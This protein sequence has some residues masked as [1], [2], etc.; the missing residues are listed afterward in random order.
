MAH[1]LVLP[2]SGCSDAS[3]VGG[4]AAGLARLLAAGFAVP[5]GCCVTIAAYEASLEGIGFPAGERWRLALARSGQERSRE[6]QDCREKIR[7]LELP[8]LLEAVKQHLPSI[9]EPGERRWAVRSSAT[10]EDMAGTSGAGLYRTILG[11]QWEELARGITDIWASLWDERV[12][13]YSVNMGMAAAPPAMAVVIQPLLDARVAGVAYSIHPVTGRDTQVTINAIRGLGQ[14][15]VEGKVT[16]DH[17]VLEATAGHPARVIRRMCGK[18]QERLVVRSRGL[19]AESIPSE[20]RNRL[21]LSDQQLFEIAML[22]KRIERAFQRPVDVEWVIDEERLWALQARP[23]SGIRPTSDP[24]NDDSEWSR[25]NFKETMPELPSPMGLSFLE[26]FMDVYILSHYRRLGCRIPPGLTAVRIYAGRPYLNVTLFHLLV[27]QLGG[28]PTLNVEQLG[29]HAIESPPPVRPLPWPALL[30]A[31]WLVWRELRRVLRDSSACFAEMKDLA[32]RFR[33]DLVQQLSLAETGARLDELGRWLET[34]EMT[35]GIA[36]GAGQCLQA[37][38]RFLPRWLGTDWRRLLN[39]SLQGQGNVISAQQIL[40]VADLVALAQ[41]DFAVST[42]F[43]RGWVSG[44]YRRSFEG[45]RFLSAFDRYLEDYGH[46]AVAESDIM[47]P[48][49]ADQP[50]VLLEVIR[51]QLDGPTM[52]PDELA[53][54][55]G[56]TRHQ[57]LMTIRARCG[58]RLDRWLAFQWWYRRLCRFFA[59]REANRHHLMWYSLSARNL[60]LRA[61]EL[62]AGQGL[63]SCKEDIFFLTLREREALDQVP[64]ETFA[65]VIKARRAEREHRRS[66]S[67][68]DIIRGWEDPEDAFQEA[69]PASDG[70]LRGIPVSS[71]IVSGPVRFVRATADWSRVRRGDIIVAEVIDPGMAPLFGLAGGLIVEMGGS[72]SHGAII[73]REYGLPAITNVSRAMSLLS[74]NEHVTLDAGEGVVRRD[75]AAAASSQ[76]VAASASLGGRLRSA[77]EEP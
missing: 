39:E 16:P 23:V 56:A 42:A 15:L 72:L 32:S 26:H 4:K 20:E 34:R 52:A 63:F 53:R 2:L 8:D 19:V 11:V 69:L 12:L 37:F 41:E 5:D 54:R 49:L 46:R 51:T 13:D 44:Q 7:R 77:P 17:Y 6:L 43:R 50:E 59:L 33:P 75:Q 29:G 25:A 40:R 66:I 60:L 64:R 28:D 61:G 1:P 68:P 58:W 74:E 71:G 24:T 67:V 18:Q 70:W 21:L 36:A 10:N 62:L 9:A 30:R 47:S 3:L 22:V 55:Q 57:A 27:G 31:G 73:A 65:E 38:N 45:T 35:F 14:S 48:R 76:P